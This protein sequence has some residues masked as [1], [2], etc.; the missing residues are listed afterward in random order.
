M[1]NADTTGVPEGVKLKDYTGPAIITKAGTVIDAKKVTSC[2][3]IKADNVTIKKSLIRS[4]GC[5]FNVLSDNGNRDLTLTDVEI[6]GRDNATG[7]SAINGGGFTCL[8]CNIHGTIDGIKAQSDVVIQDS[9]IHDLT[10]TADS[11]ND[12]IQ[13]LGTTSLRILGNSIVLDDGSTSAIILSTGSAS[14]MRNVEI[15]GNLL[16]GGAFTVYGGYLA[17]TDSPDKVSNIAITNNRFT[18]KIHPK[19]GA[20]GPLTS[21]DPPVK[22]S[23]NTWNDGPKAGQLV[24]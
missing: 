3:V 5:F 1:P 4:R 21:I 24:S 6:D 12:G 7:D 18:T 9:Y 19:S 20:F 23:G 2:L 16:G 10:I 8:R 15:D 14:A 13:S 11:H 22:V 17:G